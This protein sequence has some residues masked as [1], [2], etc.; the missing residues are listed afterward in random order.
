[1]RKHTILLYSL[2]CVAATAATRRLCAPNWL[3]PYRFR[4][5][6]EEYDCDMLAKK[7]KDM[8]DLQFVTIGQKLVVSAR[9]GG[10]CRCR[11]G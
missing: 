10:R 5:S 6:E 3:C 8:L 1:M 7:L 11:A 4:T 2:C 9:C